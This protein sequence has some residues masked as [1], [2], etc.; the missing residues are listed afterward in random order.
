MMM[1]TTMTG[2]DG[3]MQLVECN[4]P[5]PAGQTLW[6]H[7]RHGRQSDPMRTSQ[8]CVQAVVDVAR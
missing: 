7:V 8:W 5:V 4:L 1:M 3:S 2:F 6:S